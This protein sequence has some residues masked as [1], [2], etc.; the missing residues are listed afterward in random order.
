MPISW[1]VTP[2]SLVE[3]YRCTWRRHSRRHIP[4]LS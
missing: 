1:N 4:C 2:C 3:V